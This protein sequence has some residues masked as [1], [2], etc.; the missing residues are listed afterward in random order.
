MPI[1]VS[2]FSVCFLIQTIDR[3]IHRYNR[4]SWYIEVLALLVHPSQFQQQ[5]DPP[6]NRKKGKAGYCVIKIFMPF[7]LQIHFFTLHY[8]PVL[9]GSPIFWVVFP[10][11]C[12]IHTYVATGTTLCKNEVADV[13]IL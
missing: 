12:C 4:I 10:F 3:E 13:D 7:C 6:T 8:I 9:S 11:Y 1:L 5:E 2:L